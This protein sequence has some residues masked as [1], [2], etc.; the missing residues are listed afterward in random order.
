VKGPTVRQ[1]WATLIAVGAKRHETRRLED[2]CSLLA[3][4]LEAFGG[5]DNGCRAWELADV[6]RL[7]QAIS[8]RSCFRRWEWK[9]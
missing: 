8:A 9:A 2:L 7:D 3:H 4:D 5:F 6:L 1:P